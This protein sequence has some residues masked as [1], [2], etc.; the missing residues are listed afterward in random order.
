MKKFIILFLF[1]GVISCKETSKNEAPAAQSEGEPGA[2]RFERVYGETPDGYPLPLTGKP[3]TKQSVIIRNEE[4]KLKDYPEYFTPGEELGE[5]EIR[6]TCIGSGNPPVRMRQAASSWLVELGNGENFIFDIGGGTV[7]NLWSLGIPMAK[8]DKLFVTHTHL[9]HVGGILP[10]YDAMGWA[11]NTPLRVWGASGHDPTLG[12]AHFCKN[13]EEASNWHTT[14]KKGY[15]PSGG[16]S[17]EVNEFDYSK[18]SKDNPRQEVYNHNGVVIYAFPV[19]HLLEGAVGYRLE[20]KGLSFVYTGDSEPTSFEAEQSKGVD[21]FA[22][23]LF[24]DAPTFAK[25]NNMPVQVAE[26]VVSAH[27]PPDKLG[28]VF[29]IAQPGIGVGTHYFTNDDTIDP[30]FKGLRSTYDGPAVIS[31]DLMV[32]NVTPDQIVCRMAMTDK[33]MWAPPTEKTEADNQMDPVVSEGRT[34]AWLKETAIK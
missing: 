11:R 17:I 26:N 4:G 8:L 18:F 14:S 34:P 20:W 13:I 25:K 31:Q 28:Q 23:E 22:H 12:I 7:L 9:D 5:N 2:Y 29:A 3:I 33:L 30:A 1:F 10:L 19:D 24:I 15:I 6:V 32:I 16:M 27:T 21:V